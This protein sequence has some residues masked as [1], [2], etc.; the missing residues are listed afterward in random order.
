M[1]QDKSIRY[2]NLYKNNTNEIIF[3]V[4]TKVYTVL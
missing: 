1:V 2:L 3:Y 4:L